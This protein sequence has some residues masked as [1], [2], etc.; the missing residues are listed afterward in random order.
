MNRGRLIGII[1]IVI[2]FRIAAIVGLWLAVSVSDEQISTDGAVL[3]AGLAFIPVALFAGFG[4]FMYVKGGQEA[5]QE[6]TMRKQRQL[7]DILRSR[8]QVGV[9]D[10][11][12]ELNLS[13]DTVQDM[14]HQLVG[15]Q[16]F[17]GYINWDDGILFSSDAAKLRDLKQCEKC[18]APIELVGKGVVACK[19]CGTEYFLA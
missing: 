11:A 2:G 18:G 1:L 13:V 8:G 10:M 16:V 17:S 4:I 15:L 5:E 3:G 6:S 19:A 14:V 12:L 9:H 7:L